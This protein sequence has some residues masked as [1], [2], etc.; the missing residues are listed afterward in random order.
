MK[1]AVISDNP[2]A[3]TYLVTKPDGTIEIIKSLKTYCEANR[4]TYRNAQGVLEGKQ[5]HHKNYRFARLEN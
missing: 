2:M 4:L 5:A 1:I 3:K